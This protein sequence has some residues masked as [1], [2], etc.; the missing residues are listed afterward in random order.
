MFV[1]KISPSGGL[2]NYSTYLASDDQDSAQAITVDSTFSAIVSG[3]T[4]STTFPF[5]G[6]FSKGFPADACTAFVTKLAPAGDSLIYSTSLGSQTFW[7]NGVAVD[8][9]GNAYITG[10]GYTDLGTKNA[11][12]QAYVAK[13]SPVGVSLYFRQLVGSDGSSVGDA[14]AVDPD[15][16]TWVGGS[17]SST[18]FPGAPPVQPNPSAGFVVKLDKIGNGPLYTVLLG[19][20]VNGVAVIKPKPISVALPVFPS[21]FAAGIRFTGGHAQS[22]L[23]GFV[24][25]LDEGSTTVVLNH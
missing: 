5:A 18:T 22:N 11:A 3:D 12:A 14:I 1:T 19:A 15:G 2:R 20:A 9:A 4:C 13:L 16:N 21:I 24:V 6:F 23:D 10:N 8:S 17:T 25:R 7:G